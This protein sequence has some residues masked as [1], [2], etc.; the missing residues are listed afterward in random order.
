MSGGRAVETGD[1]EDVYTSPT[2]DYTK[3]LLAAE[4]HPDPAI[5]RERRRAWDAL[6][7]SG[8]AVLADT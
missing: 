4:P 2:K 1:T 3:R 6:T 8:S 5:Q 7:T